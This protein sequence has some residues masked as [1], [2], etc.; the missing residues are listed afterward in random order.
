[1]SSQ[2]KIILIGTTVKTPDVKMATTGQPVANFLL[3]VPRPSNN[4]SPPINDN[5]P[6]VAWRENAELLEN[7]AE[8]TQ[9][10]VEGRIQTRTYDTNEGVRKYVTE[11]DARLIKILSG[12]PSASVEEPSASPQYNF[13]NA[14][15]SEPVPEPQESLPQ[16]LE[17]KPVVNAENN[18]FDFEDP[19]SESE[20]STE[21]TENVPF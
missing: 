20:P 18:N 19:F 7:C 17:E 2:N 10:L 16:S 9:L 12:T 4:D 3:A 8:N 11:V 21:N 13:G 6:V 1:M 15:V 5:I 14:A